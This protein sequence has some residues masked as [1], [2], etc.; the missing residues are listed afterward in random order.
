VSAPP[1]TDPAAAAPGPP[2]RSRARRTL[3]WLRMDREFAI[4]WLKVTASAT[5]AWLLASWAFPNSLTI[6]AP[7]TACFVAFVTVRASFQ[8]AAQRVVAVIAGIGIAYFI[9]STFGLTIWTVVTV[10]ALGVLLGQVMRLQLGA[11]NQ[12]PISGLLIMTIGTTPGHVGER[13]VETLIGAGVSVI[14]N[15]LVFPPNHVAAARRA[16][17]DVIEE[18]S[19]VLALMA[20]GI[21]T[22][23]V[24]EDAAD[25]LH[26]AR[27]IGGRTATAE[28]AVESGADSLRLR[29]RGADLAEEQDRT[30]AAMD[31]IQIVEVQVRVLART[32]RDTADALG[33]ENHTLPPIRMGARVLTAAAGAIYAFGSAALGQTVEERATG[34]TEVEALIADGRRTLAEIN[35]DLVDM[36]A[37]N[38]AR[39]LHLGALVVETGRV[40][41]ELESGLPGE[42]E[43]PQRAGAFS[44]FRR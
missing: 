27:A 14:V 20:D 21:S 15:W 17:I 19:A 39:G 6:Y 7:I 26:R 22:R 29:P 35:N 28:E 16:V 23:W 11:A 31:V 43:P 36:T 40:L 37:A 38:L 33:D 3:G 5:I 44:Y 9:G 30:G 13:I 4:R 8:D 2:H 12:V 34:R 32:L 42:P 10:V 41:D 24:R 18:V 25:W 1:T